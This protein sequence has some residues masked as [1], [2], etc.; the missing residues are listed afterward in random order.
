MPDLEDVRRFLSDESGLAVVSTTQAD[1]RVLSSVA[2]CGVIDHPV[3]GEPRLAL[4]SMGSAARLKHVRRGSAVTIAIRRGWQWIS[5]TGTADLV[6]PADQIDGLDAETLRLLLRA[7]FV[8]AGGTHDDF[9]AY[10]RSMVEEGR[11]AVLVSPD[12]ILGNGPA[13]A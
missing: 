3:N 10:D 6:G 2:N 5:V 9:D 11:T 4:I 8:A 13:G 12:R 1:S 7:V